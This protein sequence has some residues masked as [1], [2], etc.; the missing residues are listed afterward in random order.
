MRDTDVIGGRASQ[1]VIIAHR[2]PN[3]PPSSTTQCS[4][5]TYHVHTFTH[6]IAS[7]HTHTENKRNK[8]TKTKHRTQTAHNTEVLYITHSTGECGYWGTGTQG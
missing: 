2:A 1:P 8:N 4:H 5:T 7:T 6:N 3:P